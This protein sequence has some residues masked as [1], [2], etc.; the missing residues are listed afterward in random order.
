MENNAINKIIFEIRAEA[1]L[2]AI[3]NLYLFS[4]ALK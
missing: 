4:M 3:A 1:G 2:P